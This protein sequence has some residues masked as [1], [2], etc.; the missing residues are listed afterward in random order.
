MKSN[1]NENEQ[2]V[3]INYSNIVEHKFV[4]KMISKVPIYMKQLFSAF[5]T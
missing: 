5:K 3:W 4:L 2:N 1:Y